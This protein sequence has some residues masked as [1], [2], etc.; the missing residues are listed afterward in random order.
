MAERCTLTASVAVL[1]CK[2]GCKKKNVSGEN[3]TIE[4][5]CENKCSNFLRKSEVIF[6]SSY[7]PAVEGSDKKMKTMNESTNSFSLIVESCCIERFQ[8]HK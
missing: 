7:E 5:H 2:S 8:L 4:P 3:A 1:E 6:H